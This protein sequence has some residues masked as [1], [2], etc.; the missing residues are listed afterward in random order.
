MPKMRASYGTHAKGLIPPQNTGPIGTGKRDFSRTLEHVHRTAPATLNPG[1]RARLAISFSI[2]LVQQPHI[3]T[4]LLEHVH[5]TI[6]RS[7]P[8]HIHALYA[9]FSGCRYRHCP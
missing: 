1:R 4:T 3:V 9:C 6:L 7:L 8:I 2:H 5:N